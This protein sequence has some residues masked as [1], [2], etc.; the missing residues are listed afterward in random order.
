MVDVFNGSM[1][2]TITKDKDAEH[3]KAGTF[4]LRLDNEW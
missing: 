4:T 3:L 2:E 1:R